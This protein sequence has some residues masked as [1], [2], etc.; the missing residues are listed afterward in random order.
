L[1][2]D[3]S[4]GGAAFLRGFS[5][6]AG[7]K[8]AACAFGLESANFQ[9]SLHPLTERALKGSHCARQAFFILDDHED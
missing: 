9:F 5:P 8:Q 1:P 2:D 4:E 3:L 6:S 7:L